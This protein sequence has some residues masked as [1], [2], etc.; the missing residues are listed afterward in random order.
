MEKTLISK[1][2]TQFPFF[3]LM[4]LLYGMI[5]AFCMY[6][7]FNGVTFP[8]LLWLQ[9]CLESDIEKDWAYNPKI[10]MDLY[11]RDDIACNFKL[12]D[13]QCIYHIF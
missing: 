1:M 9:Y 6:S 2:E 5:F 12:Y 11:F 7:N 10:Y 4:S 3:G 13:D 8:F